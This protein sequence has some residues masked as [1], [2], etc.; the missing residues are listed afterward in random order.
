MPGKPAMRGGYNNPGAQH[1]GSSPQGLHQHGP[2]HRNGSGHFS[3]KNYQGHNIHNNSYHHNGVSQPQVNHTN[4]PPAAHQN[5]PTGDV[6][7]E[8]K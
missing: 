6:P 7:E 2:P 1:Y 5:R 3:S 8:A 4:G